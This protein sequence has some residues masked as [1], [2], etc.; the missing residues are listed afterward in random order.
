MLLS[1]LGVFP[2][3][4]LQL[5]YLTGGARR[6]RFPW[7]AAQP[8]LCHVLPP[9]RKHEGM[10][11][12]GGSNGLHLN[13]RLLTQANRGELKLVAVPVDLPWARSRHDTSI[14]R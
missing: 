1:E 5:R 12:Q 8:A 7:L 13:P 14:V 4:G 3:E 11:L 2:L 6:W 10:N 9:L